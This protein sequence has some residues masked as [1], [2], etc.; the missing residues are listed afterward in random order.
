MRPIWKGHISFGLVNVPVTLYPAE[1][2]SD[3]Q[4]HMVDSRNH[5]RVRYQRVN[6]ETGEEV[7]WS[8][9]VKGYEYND[10]AYVL[11]A[12]EELKEAAPEATKTVEIE[13]FVD[14]ADIEPLYFDRPY[15]LEP[16]KKGHKAYALLRDSLRESGMAGIASVVIR[17]RQYISA[18]AVRGDALVLYLLRYQQELRPMDE[19]DLP[20]AADKVGVTKQELKMARTLVDSMKMKWDPSAHHDEYREALMAWIDKKVKAGDFEQSPDVAEAE[21]DETPAPVNLMDALKKS[22][23]HTG[24]RES[25]AKKASKKKKKTAAKKKTRNKAK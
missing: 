18:M 22:V 23:S 7:P 5:S 8:Q 25:K 19:L 6:S 16:G 20:G 21:E 2:R 12:D 11:L 13:G 1:Q 4:L 10:G 3:L 14:L 24:G 9:I 17:T 15:Y